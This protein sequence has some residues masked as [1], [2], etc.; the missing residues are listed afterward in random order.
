MRGLVAYRMLA[1]DRSSTAGSVLGVVA[2]IF[3]VGQ[4]LTTM[5]GLFTY[6]SVLVDH[7]GADV[8][9][10]SKNT[11]NANAAGPL[12]V[13]YVDRVSG[14]REVEWAEPVIMTAGETRRRD[15][16]YEGV[17]VV[18]LTSPRFAG[19]PWAFEE[20][21]LDVLLDYEGVTLD[22]G[23]L[24]LFGNPEVGSIFEINKKRVRLNGITKK[25]QGF[26]G[27]LVF[28]NRT[29]AREIS[30]LPPDSCSAILVKLAP[31]SD[32]G[33]SVGKMQRLLPRAKVVPTRGL[34]ASTRA[35]YIINTGMGSSF[36]FTTLMSALVGIVVI[37]LTMYTSVLNREKDFAVLRALG[38]RR[39]DIFV[40]VFSQGLII[41]AFGIFLGF[42]LLALFLQ[43]TR[44][45]TLPTFVPLWF[46]F[47]HAA[48]T[49]VLCLVGSLF[50]IRHATRVEPATA[51]R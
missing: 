48:F 23:D 18:G 40:V 22:A 30:N 34:S 10:V 16:K 33:A 42:L 44:E 31:G 46:P 8:W 29:K 28:T 43:G 3:L 36:G 21:S 12:P 35:F 25:I 39:K 51:F 5:F 15:G 38:A 50:A 17:M 19:G 49:L 1:H 4:Q 20:G 11:R 2:I 24:D 13:R 14:L 26:G 32:A 37:T 45:S 27:T 41:G 6:M 47:V 9:I 7:S